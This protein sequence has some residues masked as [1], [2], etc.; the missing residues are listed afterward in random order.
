MV[1]LH[2]GQFGFRV[3]SVVGRSMKAMI[4]R[5]TDIQ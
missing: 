3:L 5:D 1:L 2:I 4:E